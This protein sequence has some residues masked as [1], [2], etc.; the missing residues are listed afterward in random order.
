MLTCVLCN[1]EYRIGV[2]ITHTQ[3]SILYTTSWKIHSSQ[4]PTCMVF[5]PVNNYLSRFIALLVSFLLI[6]NKTLYW[7]I[8]FIVN[9]VM[10]ASAGHLVLARIWGTSLHHLIVRRRI[11]LPSSQWAILACVPS[12]S[13]T[14]INRLLEEDH[15]RKSTNERVF[16]WVA[17][18]ILF[19]HLYYKVF[20]ILEQK[21]YK[22]SLIN[23]YFLFVDLPCCKHAPARV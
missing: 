1:L 2:L 22:W 5:S 21:Y 17:I 13:L 12:P 14:V 11:T 3:T 7:L 19:G 15:R 8:V 20:W 4:F 23:R 10:Y 6:H 18:I 16:L 9:R